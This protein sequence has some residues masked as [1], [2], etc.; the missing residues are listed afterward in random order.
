MS[1]PFAHGLAQQHPDEKI[2]AVV[3]PSLVPLVKKLN[4]KFEIWAFN[5]SQRKELHLALK[6]ERPTSC[7]LLTNSF[8]SYLPYIKAG[9]PNRIGHGGRFTRFFLT[10]SHYHSNKDISQGEMNLKLLSTE[11][12]ETL[13]KIIEPKINASEAPHLLVFPGAKY[14]HAKKWHTKAYADVINAVH[15]KN[16]K[17][18]IMGTPD[19]K[20]DAQA[21]LKSVN[22]SKE[23]ENLCGSLKMAEL[24]DWL[25][26]HENLI[27]LANDS[28]AFHLL[29]SCGIPSL[30]MYF[31]TSSTAT[32]PA[33]GPFEVV[34][35][36]IEC[37]PC[38]AREC[39]LK[40]YKCRDTITAE[41]ISKRLFSLCEK[42][43][44]I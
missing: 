17:I 30:G 21:I 32:P 34:N 44:N 37:K 33:F 20:E 2:I 42:A 22:Q 26:E 35:A 8:G 28:G 41:S 24:I 12:Y 25:A 43:F 15:E 14:G 9:I 29:S 7:Y 38:F 31:S 5:K 23:V 13:T 16:W 18:T 3:D 19:E 10:H 39:P 6:K 1:F 4:S 27:A 36:E 40:H 11:P